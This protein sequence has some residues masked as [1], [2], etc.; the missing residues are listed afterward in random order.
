[1]NDTQ[2]GQLHVNSDGIW[3]GKLPGDLRL[4]LHRLARKE[5]TCFIV[6]PA[7]RD[8]L[9]HGVMDRVSRI[10]LLVV[11]K[12]L[13]EVEDCLEGASASNLFV[14]GP[15]RLRRGE[16][17]TVQDAKN[18]ETIRRLMITDI[19]SPSELRE[20]L[21]QREVTV[22]A[23]A[24]SAEGEIIDPFKG[25]RD[26]QAPRIRPVLPPH[27]AF[28]QKPLTLLKIAKNVA[29]HGFAA[30]SET[31]EQATRYSSNVLDVQPERIRP[32]LE[33]MLVNRHPDRGLC[34]LEETGVLKYVLPELQAMVGFADS[35]RVHHKDIWD[36][37]VKVVA[38]AKPHAVIRW[39]ALL[40]D[41][42]KVWTRSI[43]GKGR[44]HF[45][46]HEEMSAMLFR[47]IAARLGLEERLS[48]RVHYLILNH[49]RI[50][51]YTD[52][53]TD[54]A[55]RRLMRDTGGHLNDLLALSRADITSRQERRL[56]ELTKLL[57]DLEERMH[58]IEEEDAKTPVLPKGAGAVIMEHF[59]LEPGPLVGDL[60]DALER[61]V[62]SGEL[63]AE[64]PM[65]AY[66][67][68]LAQY[69]RKQAK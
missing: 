60:R 33:R 52:E 26:L 51:M 63:P 41:I 27:V 23:L 50:N 39:A 6:G 57:Q 28:A 14:S 53:W 54:S 8:A 2:D 62:E 1:M 66:M 17:F 24:M 47:G 34:F 44:V 3:T 59:G 56:E 46:R 40:H 11:A 22:N 16:I 64:M 4:V 25:A 48:S 10:D 61:A 43:D 49:S 35:C 29:Y 36:H 20:R 42:G 5:L 69:I 45:F 65:E 55:V 67:G 31:V 32:E 58:R 18:G 68:W 9:V 13:K 37:T 19:A 7:V 38:K 21:A 12:G 30:D 15:E